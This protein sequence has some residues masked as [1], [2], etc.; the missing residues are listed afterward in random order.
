MSKAKINWIHIIKDHMQKSMRLSDYHYPYAILISKFLNYF[1]VN[2]E[3]ETFEFVKSLLEVN[4][5]SLSKMGF[6]KINGRWVSKDGDYSGSSSGVHAEHDEED[7]EVAEGAD[8]NV[9]N[10]EQ[11]AT[12]LVL[13]QVLNIKEIRLLRCLPLRLTWSI[14][15]I[16]LLKTKGICMI[17]E[18]QIFR[19]LTTNFNAWIHFFRPLMNRL[20]LFRTIFLSC[21]M[22]KKI[23][24]KQSVDITKQPIVKLGRQVFVVLS[25]CVL[26]YFELFCFH[27]F[28]KSIC[29][30]K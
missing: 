10:E 24:E 14:G 13:E 8:M 16:A 19:T 17:F 1:D 6:T 26:L 27:I 5:G 28:L 12:D 2:F 30:D 3:D 23:E 4:N 20:K 29:A 15:W 22:G 9:Q 18:L 11:P 21:S 25:M 7:Q